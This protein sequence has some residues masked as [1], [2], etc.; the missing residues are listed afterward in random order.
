LGDSTNSN[1]KLYQA[2][3]AAQV[4]ST[5]RNVLPTWTT[6]YFLPSSSEPESPT[7]TIQETTTSV[8]T[9]DQSILQDRFVTFDVLR[10]RD[11]IVKATDCGFSIFNVCDR[12]VE[13]DELCGYTC[14]DEVISVK[15]DVTSTTLIIDYPHFRYRISPQGCHPHQNGRP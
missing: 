2:K 10:G 14:A 1:I 8:E 13:L 6:N 3:A 9:V 5:A 12:A 15:V 4:Y 7:S 11:V